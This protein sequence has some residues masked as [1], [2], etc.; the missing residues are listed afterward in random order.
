MDFDDLVGAF[1]ITSVIGGMAA[2]VLLAMSC[3]PTGPMG[4]DIM[5][6]TTIDLTG[7]GDGS[8]MQSA[9]TPTAVPVESDCGEVH[10]WTVA[11]LTSMGIL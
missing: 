6:P 10:V 8:S 5:E 9:P 2:M 1:L 7:D 4:D 3:S 11:E